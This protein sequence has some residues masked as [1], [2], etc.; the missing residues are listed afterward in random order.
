MDTL[1]PA[2]VNT[3]QFIPDIN[4]PGGRLLYGH[5]VTPVRLTNVVGKGGVDGYAQTVA[6]VTIEEEL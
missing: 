1:S 4:A 5:I 2:A 6:T 3:A